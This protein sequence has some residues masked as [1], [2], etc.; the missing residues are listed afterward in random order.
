MI[1]RLDSRFLKNGSFC[2]EIF[3]ERIL[4][5][6]GLAGFMTENM[7]RECDLLIFFLFSSG[8]LVFVIGGV[9]WGS[10]IIFAIISVMEIV[11]KLTVAW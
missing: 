8:F 9:V 6:S 2:D 1:V 7:L 5:S 10:L 3:F 11:S 4:I